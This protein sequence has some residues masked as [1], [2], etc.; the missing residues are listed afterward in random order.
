MQRTRLLLLDDHVLF[1]EGLRRLLISESDLETVAVCGTT[2]EAL[3]A[4][5]R[6]EVDVVLVDFDLEDDTGI[7]FISAAAAAG[8]KGRILIVTVG[9]STLDVSVA[10]KLGISGIFLKHNPPASLVEAI[11]VV[12]HGGIWIDPKISQETVSGGADSGRS[13][14]YLTPREQKVL[15]CVFEGLS[16]KEIAVQL[17]VSQSSVKAA[18]QNLFEKT[19]VR[20]RGQLV[21][22]AIE[23]SL[24]TVRQL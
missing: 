9:M 23:R 12:A 15:R 2:G 19:G 20:T 14:E 11:R 1:R 4:L 13:S 3:S 6:T 7:R 17:E 22:I 21:R 24:E 8:Y 18:L 10:R 5:S 16:N